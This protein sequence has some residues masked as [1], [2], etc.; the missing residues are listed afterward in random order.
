MRAK[1]ILV[2]IACLSIIATSTAA[3]QAWQYRAAAMGAQ[4]ERDVLAYQRDALIAQLATLRAEPGPAEV[5]RTLLRHNAGIMKSDAPIAIAKKV[6][7]HLHQSTSFAAPIATTS[8]DA[9][10]YAQTIGKEAGNL[11][12]S[13]SSTLVWSLE[14]FGIEAR[15]VNLYSQEALEGSAPLDTHV[16][17]EANIGGSA[18]VLDPT[19]GATYACGADSDISVSEVFIARTKCAPSISVTHNRGVH[20][21]NTISH[22]PN[23]WP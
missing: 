4:D 9:L 2:A 8:N 15:S 17:V 18:V 5:F 12:S 19:F 11:C 22:Y 10:R 20:W 23:F 16:F 14:Q 6:T 7:D 21:R 3:Y 13:L 1:H